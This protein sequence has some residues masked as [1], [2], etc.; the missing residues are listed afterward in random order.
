MNF[1]SGYSHRM[2]I[3]LENDFSNCGLPQRTGHWSAWTL[4]GIP[5]EDGSSGATEKY[6][7]N[8]GLLPGYLGFVPGFKTRK[9]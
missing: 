1:R 5:R 4:T 7:N 6:L 8:V 2:G 9:V 3:I